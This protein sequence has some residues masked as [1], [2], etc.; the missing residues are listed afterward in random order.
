MSMLE[1]ILSESNIQVLDSSNES[2]YKAQDTNECRNLNA[3]QED[4]RE[5][6]SC[7]PCC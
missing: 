3:G 5:I 6:N 4:Q 1:T 2:K 7:D